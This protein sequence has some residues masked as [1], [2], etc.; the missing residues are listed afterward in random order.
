[1]PVGFK[2]RNWLQSLS[3]DLERELPLIASFFDAP[4]RQQL[5][6]GKVSRTWPLVAED[7]RE[8]RIPTVDDLLQRATRMEFENYMPEDILVKIDR[9]SMLSSLELRAPMLDY[10]II[11][12][13]FG[14]VPSCLK[15]TVNKRKIMLKRMAAKLLPPEFDQQRKQGFSIPLADWL[16]GG[17]WRDYFHEVLLDKECLFDKKTV[18]GLIR[19]QDRGRYNQERLFGLVLFELWRREYKVSL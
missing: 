17:P 12:F 5:M 2:G 11:E 6:C 15:T 8:S 18:I 16:K 19:G 13:A 4:M 1:M 9:A 10:R 7:F 14:R 3:C